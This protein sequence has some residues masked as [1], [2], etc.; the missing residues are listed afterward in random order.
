[1]IDERIKWI[2]FNKTKK[3]NTNAFDF[4]FHKNADSISDNKIFRYM[5][6]F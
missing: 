3:C 2:F 5:K 1:M 4:Y 6:C